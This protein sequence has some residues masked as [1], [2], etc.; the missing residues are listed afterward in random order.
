MLELSTPEIRANHKLAAEFRPRKLEPWLQSLPR[1][2][3]E[4]CG[5][6]MH[7]ALTAQNRVAL[8]PA[9]R[10][11]LMEMYLATFQDI[12]ASRQNDKSMVSA[13]L[14]SYYRSRQQGL[15]RLW[16]ALATGYK[17]AVVEL[18]GQRRGR[19]MHLALALQRAIYCLGQIVIASYE[20][21][22]QPPGGTW[23]ELHE[24]YRYAEREDLR[25]IEVL[26]VREQPETQDVLRTYLPILLV[27]ASAPL[28]L[29]P[30]EARR[31]YELAPQWH[32]V[33][34]LTNGFELFSD[35][36]HFYVN[37]DADAPPIPLS[38]TANVADEGMR[39]L[40][41]LGVAK[42]MHDALT[43]INDPYDRE[44]LDEPARHPVEPGDVELFR[45]AGRVLG[46]VDVRRG[47]N[48]FPAKEHLEFCSGFTSVYFVCNNERPF[49]PS[50]VA[51]AFSKESGKNAGNDD[52]Q[53]IDLGEPMPGIPLAGG[54]STAERGGGSSLE[55]IRYRAEVADRSAGGLCLVLPRDADIR[56]KVGD[57]GACRASADSRWQLGAVRWMRVGHK[58][59][60]CGVQFLGPRALPVAAASDTRA[61]AEVETQPPVVAAI[62]LPENPTLKQPNSVL[63]PRV[64]G[65]YPS[66]LK[67]LGSGGV[68]DGVRLLGR[69]DRTSDYE[70][71]LVSPEP[72]APDSHSFLSS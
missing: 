6:R 33:M 13:P 64:P 55:G 66:R 42:L 37:L 45:R 53:F 58:D 67:L 47:S 14:N 56:L 25:G 60:K 24:L 29:Q 11:Q 50:V 8:S 1:A 12:Y 34:K 3:R 32:S 17:V 72:A 26:P 2:D 52:E 57:I 69:I 23:R 7:R 20:M 41:T 16:G 35:P 62:W 18:A 63:L 51:P 39:V 44:G 70:Q 48:R 68:P 38:K 30:G 19:Q 61:G 40:R 71:F 49:D 28:S 9:T 22:T 15:L 65:A 4:A 59:V 31:L 10:L 43:H 21:Y 36:G 54:E 27:G 5:R 46:E